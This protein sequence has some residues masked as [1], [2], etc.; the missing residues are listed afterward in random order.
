VTAR[1]DVLAVGK[2]GLVQVI[3]AGG[4]QGQAEEIVK[5][6]AGWAWGKELFFTVSPSGT[7][8]DGDHYPREE[9]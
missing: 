6:I 2:T 8:K 9:A 7:Y 3:A 4:A 5:A 1:Y